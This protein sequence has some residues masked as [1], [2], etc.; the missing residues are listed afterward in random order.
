MKAFAQKTPLSFKILKNIEDEDEKQEQVHA[1]RALLRSTMMVERLKLVSMA[2][3]AR[4]SSTRAYTGHSAN[5]RHV[6]EIKNVNLTEYARS[7]GLY[8]DV[9]EKKRPRP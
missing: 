1:L 3:I 8:K 9:N 4:S 6:F 7:F 5:M 2:Q